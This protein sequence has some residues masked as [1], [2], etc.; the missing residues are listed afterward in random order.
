MHWRWSQSNTEGAPGGIKV[1]PMVEP[2]DDKAL[3]EHFHKLGTPNLVSDQAIK[4]GIVRQD[5]LPPGTPKDPD[6]PLSYVKTPK[7]IAYYS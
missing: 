1:D 7:T 4:I 3:D 6:D 5:T 2:S